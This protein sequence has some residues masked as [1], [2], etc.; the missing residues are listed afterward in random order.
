MNQKKRKHHYVFQRYLSAW[1]INGKLWCEREGEIFF[2]GTDN[3]AQERDFYRLRPLNADE[4]KFHDLVL[5]GGSPEVQ[6]AMSIHMNAYLQPTKWQDQVTKLKRF[7]ESEFGGYSKI[8]VE[9]Q[10]C[11]KKLE[12]I[13][14]TAINNTDEDYYCE[15]EGEGS[16]WLEQLQKCDTSFYYEHRSDIAKVEYYDDEQF[17][18]I[19][20]VC[21]QYFRTKAIR[22]RWIASFEPHLDDPRF[23][24]L[25]IPRENIHIENIFPHVIWDVQ[26]MT[27]F[28]LRK[29][30]APL[31][32]L[33]NKTDIPFITSDQ[34]VI[35]LY[36]DY[37][38]P[39]E[40]SNGLTFYYPISPDVAILLNSEDTQN[41]VYLT[42]EQVDYYNRT[43][44]QAS[45]QCIFANKREVIER[46]RKT[47]PD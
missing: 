17:H 7:F 12:L 41:K 18:F 29:K 32:L 42:R 13:A 37:Q 25:N 5:N 21:T 10:C 6:R 26:N 4:R 36:A 24:N 33:V 20:F 19:H 27:A 1:T 23:S 46:Y 30:D 9:L 31:S 39:E 28:T 38:K 14:D 47:G 45:Y 8:P 34:P 3:V 16:K 40:E 44:I 43:I 2:T 35:N 11:I 22:E 15:I